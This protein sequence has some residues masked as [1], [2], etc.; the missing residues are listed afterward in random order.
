MAFRIQITQATISGKGTGVRADIDVRTGGQQ[1]A[2]AV[3]G[4]GGALFDLGIKQQRIESQTQL[5]DAIMADESLTIL[6][7]EEIRSHKDTSDEAGLYKKS[8]ETFETKRKTFTPKNKDAARRYSSYLKRSRKN[9]LRGSLAIKLARTK[10]NARAIV[11]RTSQVYIET[12]EP[13]ILQRLSEQLNEGIENDLFTE[14]EA[15][16]S[17]QNAKD[18]RERF[19]ITKAVKDKKL[20][21]ESS[22]EAKLSLYKKEDEG[23]PLTRVDFNAVYPDPDDADQFYDEYL[24]GQRAEL[25]GEA[26]FVKEGNPV[27][28]AKMNAAID[29]NPLSVTEDIIYANATNGLGTS[30]VTGLVDRLRK[31]KKDIF[32]PIDKYNTQFSTLLNAGYFGDKDKLET[33]TRFLDMKR[34][35][36]E[37][38]DTQKPTEVAADAFFGGLVTKD[39]AVKGWFTGAG[40]GWDEKGFEHKY[41]DA[42]GNEVTAFFR[43]GDIRTRN[44]N[45]KKIE[46]FYAGTTSEGVAIWIPRR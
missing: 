6:Y 10:D 7:E 31:R 12:G 19:I 40:G 8:L 27:K 24:A 42:A 20:A 25:R 36:K 3:S 14:L 13:I 45:G 22:K 9:I 11:F 2:Q 18:D 29:L 39:F 43:F 1:V 23:V 30:N 16:K 21:K 17:L 32:T 15:E 34:R 4:L 44:V 37:Y 26:N 46:E 38:I 41:I 28:I 35:M 33:S 5:D